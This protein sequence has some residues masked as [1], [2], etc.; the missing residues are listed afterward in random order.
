MFEWG[1]ECACCALILKR[2][3]DSVADR[4]WILDKVCDENHMKVIYWKLQHPLVDIFPGA[5]LL[6]LENGDGDGLE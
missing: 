3:N 1:S 4:V 5:S 2:S 6:G